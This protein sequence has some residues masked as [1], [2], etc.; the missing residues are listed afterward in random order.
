MRALTSTQSRRNSSRGLIAGAVLALTL[1]AQTG[2]VAQ[3][4]TPPANTQVIA[5]KQVGSWTVIGWSQGYCAGEGRC[6]VL[7]AGEPHCSSFLPAFR[8]AI[9]WPSAPRSGS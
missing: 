9:V 2:A 1:S 5:P 4:N 3:I 6:P 8:P 7:Q